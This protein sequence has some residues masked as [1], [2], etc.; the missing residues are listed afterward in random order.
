[1]P[2]K[3]NLLQYLPR[4]L[5]R[6][7]TE[8]PAGE[9]S[10]IEDFLQIFDEQLKKFESQ[11][12]RIPNL[13]DP[14]RA[15]SKFLPYLASWLALELPEEWGERTQRALINKIV[16]IYHTRGTLAGL[17]TILRIYLGD[18]VKELKE[19]PTQAHLFT[20]TFNFP[21][22]KPKEL[23]G[24]TRAIR[25]VIDAE[26]PAQTDYE[27]HILSPTLQIGKH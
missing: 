5:Q 15:D 24:R 27:W 1:M 19:H 4:V 22:F 10:F 14:W 7:A 9:K 20:V 23:A 2:E 13:F 16:S 18:A 8:L 11:V 6:A 25:K 26:K 21:N 3:D 12:D 17:E